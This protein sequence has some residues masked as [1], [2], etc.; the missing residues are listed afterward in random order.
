MSQFEIVRDGTQ[1][2]VALRDKLTAA[3]VSE[4][5]PALKDEIAAGVREIVL[6][7]AQTVSIDSM[8]IGLLIATN[9]SLGA[10]QGQIRML[11][12]SPDIFALLRSMRLIDR[13][14]VTAAAKDGSN[15]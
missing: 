13:L 7:L 6:D 14:Q 10:V 5:Q 9:N 3:D 8:G 4:L 15:G 1:A 12:V 2:M 11:N